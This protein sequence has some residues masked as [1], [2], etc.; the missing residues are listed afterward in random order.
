MKPYEGITAKCNRL[1]ASIVDLF[2]RRQIIKTVWIPHT[3]TF[4]CFGPCEESCKKID[5][6]IIKLFW[7]RKTAGEIK[8]GSRL[9]AKSMIDA[10]YEMGGLKMDFTMEIANGLVPNGLQ[11]IRQQG[12]TRDKN[13]SFLFKLY[14]ECLREAKPRGTF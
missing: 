1:N 4:L 6:K 11:R 2:H 9:V 7:N 14:S 5:G 10:S 3:T 13:K 12:R 8:R